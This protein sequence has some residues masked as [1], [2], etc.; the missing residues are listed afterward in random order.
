MAS[1]RRDPYAILGT[2]RAASRNEIAA[3]YRR[4]AKAIHPDVATAA[5]PDMRDLNWAW[6]VLSDSARRADWDA[7]HPVGGSHWGTSRTATASWSPAENAEVAASA[8]SAGAGWADAPDLPGRR[9][10]FGCV[11]LMV[12]AVL[13]AGLV[14]IAALYST[15]P[16]PVNDQEAQATGEP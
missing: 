4:L 10:A 1:P 5:S 15:V 7:A 8:W 13:L 11:G 6:H 16:E 3:A 2:P 12:I 14:L 9:N